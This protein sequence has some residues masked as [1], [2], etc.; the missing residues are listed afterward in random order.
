MFISGAISS[1]VWDSPGTGSVSGD[2]RYLSGAVPVRLAQD[3]G[4]R[5]NDN[6]AAVLMYLEAMCRPAGLNGNE[7]GV[8]GVGGQASGLAKQVPCFPF[9]PEK[10]SW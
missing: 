8:R 3:E 9:V 4:L 2:G 5:E 1:A 10:R 7:T 6:P